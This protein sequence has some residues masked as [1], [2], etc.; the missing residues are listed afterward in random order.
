MGHAGTHFRGQERTLPQESQ[1][2]LPYIVGERDS[3]RARAKWI[4]VHNVLVREPFLGIDPEAYALERSV[5]ESLEWRYFRGAKMIDKLLEIWAARKNALH[6]I[7]RVCYLGREGELKHAQL[8]THCSNE[9][10]HR[11]W[12]SR[13]ENEVREVRDA[14]DVCELDLFDVPGMIM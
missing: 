2:V 4:N 13:V 7:G 3:D 8:P 10:Q 12:Y 9:R 5:L 11:A 1:I 6:L 14:R